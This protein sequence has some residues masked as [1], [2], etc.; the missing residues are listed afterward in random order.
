MSYI[1]YWNEFY[2]NYEKILD[3]LPSLYKYTCNNIFNENINAVQNCI[4]YGQKGFP[5]ETLI[6]YAISKFYSTKF[7]IYKR[8]PLWNNTLPYIETNYYFCI[9]TEHPEFPKDITSL[10]EFIKHIVKIKSIYNEKHIIIIKNIDNITNRNTCY[11]FRILLEKFNNNV[12]FLCTAHNYQ[13][14]ERPLKSRSRL[15]RL[16]LPTIEQNK[17]I[18]QLLKPDFNYDV[19]TRNLSLNI[20]NIENN[21]QDI[22]IN[23]PPLLETINKKLKPLEIRKIT[24]QIFQ[25]KIS[26][27]EVIMDCMSLIKNDNKKLKWIEESSEIELQSKKTDNNKQFFF[28]EL[29]LNK[30]ED[31]KINKY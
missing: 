14:I 19:Y 8:Y 10:V 11:I 13:M 2:N 29:L 31:Y 5:F 16:P 21:I 3:I 27:A 24:Y 7:P 1:N 26:L 18:L 12:L 22:T 20:F 28:I 6:E 15:F 30:F 17:Q 4:L 9:D 25:Y 23:Y